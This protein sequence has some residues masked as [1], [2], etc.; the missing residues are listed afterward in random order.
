MKKLGA[1]GAAG[2]AILVMVPDPPSKGKRS[3]TKSQD[4]VILG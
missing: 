1:K 3:V 4:L 2:G